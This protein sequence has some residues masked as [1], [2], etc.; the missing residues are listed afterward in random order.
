MVK[1]I[2]DEDEAQKYF[3]AFRNEQAANET[4]IF[5]ERVSYELL[6]CIDSSLKG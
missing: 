2:N 4:E 6:R 5:S 1:F 3:D